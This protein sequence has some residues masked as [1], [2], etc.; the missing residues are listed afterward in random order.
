M[1]EIPAAVSE[2]QRLLAVAMTPRMGPVAPGIENALYQ[3]DFCALGADSF[4]FRTPAGARLLYVRGQP[5]TIDPG[6]ADQGEIDLYLWGTVYGAVAWLNGLVALHAGAVEVEGRA[7]AF[8]GAS[9]A[10]K[11]TLVAALSSR[12][13]GVLCD[14]TL[15]LCEAEGDIWALPD[16]KPL[17]LTAESA[18]I[19]GLAV[20]ERIGLVPNKTLVRA[21]ERAE[22]PLPMSTLYELKAGSDTR[23]SKVSGAAKV[24]L[25]AKSL[26]RDQFHES[27]TTEAAHAQLMLGLATA[28]TMKRFERNFDLS[29]FDE[30][31]QVLLTDFIR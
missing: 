12:G 16:P 20:G 11:S 5:V 14:D 29:Q 4:L 22:R 21:G 28:I 8:T 3:D 17:K 1:A 31:L 23:I 15:I 26:Y 2:A 10:G 7:V 18:R 24:E 9:G 6:D 13:H 30:Q 25:L 27:R 19:A